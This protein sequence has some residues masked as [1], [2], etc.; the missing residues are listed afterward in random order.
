M[1]FK[2]IYRVFVSSIFILLV[3]AS[4]STEKDVFVNRAYHNMT[5]RYNGYYNAK[6]IIA[7]ALEAF[8]EDYS[9]NYEK[10]IPLEL[11]PGQE[12]VTAM[13][14]QLDDAIER[15]SKVVVRHSMPNPAVVKNKKEEYGKW[16]DDNWLVIGKAYYIK[17]EY[18]EAKEKLSYVADNYKGEA[19]IYEARIWLAKTHIA[20]GEYSEA[21]RILILVKKSIDQLAEDKGEKTKKKKPS[22]LERQRAKRSGKKKE[23]EPAKFPKKLIEDYEITMAELFLA[24]EDYKNAVV[25]LEGGIRNCKNK[26]RKARYMFALAQTYAKLGNNA[27]ASFYYKKVSKSNAPYEMQF[28]AKIKHTLTAQGGSEELVKE[29]NKMLKDGKNLE[30]KDQ[31]YY[32]LA[33]LDM[34]NNDVAAAKTNYTQSVKW[35]INNDRQKGVSYLRLADIHFDEKDYLNAQRYY[36]SSVQVLPK[37]YEGYEQLQ[38]KASGLSDLVFNYETVVFEDSVQRIAQMDPKQREKFLEKTIKEI[39]AEKERKKLEAEQRLLAQQQRV[40]QQQPKNGSGSKWYFYNSKQIA[41]GFNDFRGL[42]GQRPLEDNW[43]RAD[44]A[45][46]ATFV[47][48]DGDNTTETDDPAEGLTVEDLSKDLPLTPAAIDS[49]NNRILNALYAL[50]IIYKEQLK[51]E[52]EAISYFN[53]VIDRKIEHERV[54]P[55]LYQLY[56]IYAKKGDARAEQYKSTIVND[57]PKSEIAQILIDPDYLQ[58]KRS[59]DREELLAYSQLLR[60]YKQRMYGVVITKANEVITNDPENSFIN[61]YYLLK[62]FALSKINAGNVASISAPLKA[63]YELDPSS[64]EGQQAKIYLNQLK[65][66]ENI[67]TPD[68]EKGSTGGTTSPYVLDKNSNYF[69]LVVIPSNDGSINTTK[70]NISNFNTEFY[71]NDKLSIKNAPLGNDNQILIV[72]SFEDLT[73][74]RI[75]LSSYVSDDAIEILDDIP[76]RYEECIITPANFATLFKE[77]DIEAYLD[78]YEANY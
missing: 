54:L 63:L 5:A 33:E 2:S 34:K 36:D 58:N 20:V 26:K 64:E 9:E 30:Y 13:Y 77:K 3:S 57:Y 74:A 44:K 67:T 7:E 6:V 41:S 16:I 28:R 68:E 38:N 45:S 31:I 29:L 17:R 4:C 21:K 48:E 69:F 71:R 35:S 1:A 40:N 73:K 47:N 65:S 60:T 43:R 37:D 66:G 11:Y 46:A 51:E 62:A 70:I 12:D 49:S 10:I 75:Y 39:E 23:K 55:S 32:A 52:K 42:W 27:Q 18:E 61:K 19:S 78:F 8:R 72:R 24:Q 15:C 59:K 25:H 56:L 53:A 22:K 76:D 14:P 50:G